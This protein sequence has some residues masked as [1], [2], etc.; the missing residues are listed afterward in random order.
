MHAETV[1]WLRLLE[2]CGWNPVLVGLKHQAEFCSLQRQWVGRKPQGG[3]DA[4]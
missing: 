2:S 3:A 1:F 4:G